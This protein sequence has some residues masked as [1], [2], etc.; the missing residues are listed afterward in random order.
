MKDD[1]KKNDEGAPSWRYDHAMVYDSSRGKT[2]LF[3]GQIDLEWISNVEDNG[4]IYL[5]DTWEWDGASWTKAAEEDPSGVLAPTPRHSH[6][7]VYDTSR[8]VTVLF[9]GNIAAPGFLGDT[10]E[11]DGTSWVKM[12]EEDDNGVLAPTPRAYHTMT[13]DASREVTLLFGGNGVGSGVGGGNLGDTW[14]WVA[15]A[16]QAATWRLRRKRLAQNSPVKT[17]G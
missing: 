11:W 13:Y 16:W 17:K 6:A 3:G 10:W 1:E 2:V 9:G 7:M 15:R 5:G 4:F 8:R 14:E 12:A